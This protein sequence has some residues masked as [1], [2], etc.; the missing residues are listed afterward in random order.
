MTFCDI[1]FTYGLIVLC[2]YSEVLHPY[3]ILRVHEHISIGIVYS[4]Y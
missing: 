4:R 3:V 2:V 1:N